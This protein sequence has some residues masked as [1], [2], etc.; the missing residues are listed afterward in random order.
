MQREEYN[1]VI[2]ELKSMPSDTPEERAAR[3]E[4]F[5][6]QDAYDAVAVYMLRQMRSGA[7]RE[8]TK[9][10][11]LQEVQSEDFDMAGGAYADK[12]VNLD[13]VV[14]TEA[15]KQTVQTYTG[16]GRS[17]EIPFLA[18]VRKTY[19]QMCIRESG[20]DPLKLEGMRMQSRKE[21]MYYVLRLVRSTRE[22]LERSGRRGNAREVLLE[23]AAQEKIRLSRAELEDALDCVEHLGVIGRLDEPLEDEDDSGA[24]LG[25]TVA[26]PKDSYAGLE[27]GRKWEAFL[28][29]F[30]EG[31]ENGWQT[32]KSASGKKDREIIQSF[33]S[34]DILIVLKLKYLEEELRREYR[35]QLEPK[36][37]QW[38]HR[39][40]R[41]SVKG[42]GCY[43]R[44][45]TMPEDR[46]NGADDIYE[47]LKGQAEP[48]Y[49]CILN[50]EYVDRA[51]E[52]P[53]GSL[54]DIY[55][56]KLK[57]FRGEDGD[58]FQF[59]DAVLAK[60]LGIGDRSKISR[61]RKR[62]ET[63]TRNELYKI[64]SRTEE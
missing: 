53:P 42:E 2:S 28:E 46:E 30:S 12:S 18:C 15:L 33:L 44:Y 34:K 20:Q 3:W 38:C 32:V 25:D 1:H 54:Y 31:L 29:A 9:R 23:C 4:W 60:A 6:G 57:D 58:T 56:G 14:F 10:L 24:S 19:D 11:D 47:K 5:R 49:G 27:A 63:V 64:F 39:S 45:G 40:G 17:G 13:T 16:E 51:F 37:R 7:F 43:I 59:T 55:T 8:L 62:Y 21:R 35:D 26:D 61:M 22:A 36:C 52:T 50:N 41:C 48:L